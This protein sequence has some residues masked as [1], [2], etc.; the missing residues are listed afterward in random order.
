MSGYSHFAVNFPRFHFLTSI[1]QLLPYDHAILTLVDFPGSPEIIV[2]LKCR[3]A[4]NPVTSSIQTHSKACS[5]ERHIE[6]VPN[7]VMEGPT[8]Q[9]GDGDQDSADGDEDVDKELGTEDDLN[10]QTQAVVNMEHDLEDLRE[11]SLDSDLESIVAELDD[12]I[13]T[14]ITNS[15]VVARRHERQQ[16]RA[17]SKF[18]TENYNRLLSSARTYPI[19]IIPAIRFFSAINAF[20]C[21]NDECSRAFKTKGAVRTHIYKKH[22]AST[23]NLHF[24]NCLAQTLGMNGPRSRLFVVHK[25]HEEPQSLSPPDLAQRI[26][27][28]HSEARSFTLEDLSHQDP[29]MRRFRYDSIYPSDPRQ[30]AVFLE[31]KIRIT[32]QLHR[33]LQDPTL[34]LLSIAIFYYMAT[35]RLV[36]Y[37][38]DDYFRR[39]FGNKLRF[40]LG[41]DMESES[42]FPTGATTLSHTRLHSDH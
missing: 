6:V 8:E 22:P 2:C 10:G 26:L 31:N 35:T 11:E 28:A 25:I 24:E 13:E 34:Q 12:N 27:D 42:H 37:K 21:P 15:D 16:R 1:P 20:R 5:G 17:L 18:L 33:P 41:V 4:A 39:Q 14:R 29:F 38:C 19:R 32:S 40:V 9:E 36:H 23:K 3:K 7:L 30:R